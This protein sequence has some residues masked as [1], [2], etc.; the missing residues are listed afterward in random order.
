MERIANTLIAWYRKHRRELPWRETRDPYPIW[1]SEVILQQTRVAQ[2]TEYYLRFMERF[3]TLQE[4]AAAPEDELLKLWQGLGYYSRARNLHAAAQRVADEFGGVFPRSY[5]QVRSL[6]GIGPYTA[7]AICSFAY[8]LPTAVVDGN[9]YRFLSRLLDCDL[10]IDSSAGVRHFAQAAQTLLDACVAAGGS[11]AEFNQ[12]LM[13]FGS[14]CCTPARPDCTGCPLADRCL[15]LA[16]GRVAGLPVRRGKTTQR[17]RYF[18]YLNLIDRQ[19]NT[20]LVQRAGKDIWQ[21]L[22]EFPLIETAAPTGFDELTARKEFNDLVGEDFV[23]IKSVRMPKHQ[24][25]HQ[26]IHALFHRLRVGALPT[27]QAIRPVVTD[28]PDRLGVSRL[29]ERYLEDADV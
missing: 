4:L 27:N 9:V 6:P 17:H 18:N 22:Y 21:G 14:L 25:S 2:G 20:L 5:D 13:E 8:D 28:Q 26:V 10:A 19:G 24:L 12:A 7:A 1:I 23:L 16:A 29:T 15:G 3:A 11:S